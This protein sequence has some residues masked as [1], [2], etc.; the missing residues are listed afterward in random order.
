[1]TTSR[2]TSE[3]IGS[4]PDSAIPPRVRVRVFERANGH[5]QSCTRKIAAGD[6]WQADHVV[7][8]INGGAN[9]ESNL[10]CLCGWCHKGKTAGDV[11]EKSR[12]ARI[13]AKHLGVKRKS[14]FACSRDSKHRRK[15]NGRVELR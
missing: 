8:L 4:T 2:S 5:C 14:T 7:A 13:K 12:T 10:Q 1:M 3:W 11:A 9:R 6:A 15:I